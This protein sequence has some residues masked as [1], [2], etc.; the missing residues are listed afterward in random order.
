MAGNELDVTVSETIEL[1]VDMSVND[2]VL[3][4][5]GGA[6]QDVPIDHSWL[7][8]RDKPD[9]HPTKAITGLDSKLAEMEFEAMTADDIL[10]ICK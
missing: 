10:A 2:R 6:S 3:N 8:G 4:P 5:E 9:Q 7:S 1:D